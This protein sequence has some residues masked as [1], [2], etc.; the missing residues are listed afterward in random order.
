M[1]DIHDLIA[2]ELFQQKSLAALIW[3]IDCGREL[4]F[5]ADGAEC[6]I[7]RSNSA[8]NV[9]L[10]VNKEEQ[11]F[12]RIDLL[13]CHAVIN[14]KPFLEVWERTELTTLF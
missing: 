10:W 13:I 12:D 6:F 7:S 14:G 2:D 11:A 5:T 9:S 3:L 8:R 4:E 1:K